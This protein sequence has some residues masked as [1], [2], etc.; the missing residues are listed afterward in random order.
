MMNPVVKETISPKGAAL[1]LMLGLFLCLAPAV[2]AAEKN[3]KYGGELVLSSASDPKSFNPILAKETSTTFITGMLFE[4][5]TTVDPFTLAPKPNLAEHWEVGKDGLVW[6]FH[7]RP[8]LRWSDGFPLTADDVTF[9][10]NDLIFN[11]DVPSSSKDIFTISGQ[12]IKVEKVDGLTV[13]FI[14]PF[15]FAPFLRSLGQEILP[16]HILVK[17]VKDG[18]FN[19]TWGIDAAPDEVVG[20]G[21]FRLK[22]YIPGQRVELERNPDYWKR[23]AEGE[24]LPY[25]DRIVVL[26]VPS[27]DV[28]LLKFMEG[29]ADI[30]DLRGMDYPL[31]KPQEKARNF[32]VFDRGPDLGSSF[33]VFNL[34]SGVNPKTGK[35]FVAP[36]KL[37]WFKDVR[38]RRAVAYAVD[39]K[40]I[41]DIVKN[42]L[43]YPQYSPESPAVGYFY[44]DNVRK[45]HYDLVKAKALLND[46]GFLD[47]N[48]DGVLEDQDGHPLEFN[49]YT[50]ADN[51]ERVDIAS[52]IRRD[53]ES[54]GMKVNFLLVEFN[55]LVSKLTSTY[56]W[57]AIVLGLTGSIDPHFGQNVWLSSGQLHMWNPQQKEPATDWEKRVDELFAIGAQELDETKRKQD[58]DEYQA[59][60]AEQ[61]PM[62]YTVLGARLTAVRNK[63]GNMKPAPY[64]GVLHNLEEIYIKSK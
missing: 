32:T 30:Y 12:P 28:E 7:L 22:R 4:G 24:P 17:A 40:K 43:G 31:L 64:G 37:A 36:H 39:R 26:I 58:Y 20:S 25:L 44:N 41:I 61:V 59:I 19:F 48:G 55:T 33:L 60:I 13:R 1:F 45:Y 10:F 35:P 56:E 62:V 52:I 21:P 18:K 27:L 5:L 51:T 14:L 16:R 11:P 42:G 2:P 47:R 23:S 63:F 46:A 38:F 6:T 50:N 54:L 15:K 3:V 8:D 49:L 29:S 53:L 57:D 34:N 9:T